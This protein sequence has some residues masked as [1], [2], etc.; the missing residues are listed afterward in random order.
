MALW[1]SAL[2]TLNIRRSRKGVNDESEC[3]SKV[4]IVLLSKSQ[5]SRLFVLEVIVLMRYVAM[6]SCPI[7]SSGFHLEHCPAKVGVRDSIVKE[8][9]LRA[10]RLYNRLA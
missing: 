4:S 8:G 5:L 10:L 2:R 6:T 9:G 7:R 1:E 3:E